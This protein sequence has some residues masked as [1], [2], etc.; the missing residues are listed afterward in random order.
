MG[1]QPPFTVKEME[2]QKS[3]GP[4]CR[5]LTGLGKDRKFTEPAP[6]SLYILIWEAAHQP[7]ADDWEN[8]LPRVSQ[9][10]PGSSVGKESACNAGDSG[11]IPGWR[12]SPREGNG[13]PLQYSSLENIMDRGA[14]RS[15]V[16][17][18]AESQT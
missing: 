9:G 1:Y 2:A 4:Q 12:R 6:P 11:S 8:Q 3:G 16:H 5:G 18:I 10:F 7:G 13:N 15:I 17:G 14:W